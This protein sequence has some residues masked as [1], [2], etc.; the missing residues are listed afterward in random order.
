MSEATE[1]ELEELREELRNERENRQSLEATIEEMDEMIESIAE[2]AERTSVELLKTRSETD[3]IL[4]YVN[5]GLFL[6]DKELC[7]ESQYS[8]AFRDILRLPDEP[9]GSNILKL[10]ESIVRED[11]VAG[12]KIYLKLLMDRDKDPSMLEELNPLRDVE[13]QITS[14]DD[15]VHKFLDFRF[16]RIMQAGDVSGL[17]GVVVDVT[18]HIEMAR[19]VRM[20]EK[21][22]NQDM[23]LM[24]N[25]VNVRPSQLNDFFQGVETELAA[26]E[27]SLQANADPAQFADTLALVFRSMHAIKGYASTLELGL[28]A[29]QAHEAENKIQDLQNKEQLSGA[30]FLPLVMDLHSLRNSYADSKRI[31]QNLK[32]FYA[33][34]SNTEAVDPGA[35]IV[36]QLGD[37]IEKKSRGGLLIAQLLAD[38]F[39]A[40]I[41]PDEKLG[42][43][44]KILIQLVINSL[45][46]GIEDRDARRRRNK[47][48][49]GIIDLRSRVLTDGVEVTYRDDGG[50]LQV[51]KIKKRA[52]EMELRTAGQLEAM[53]SNE[54]SRLI[55]ERGMSTRE[56]ADMTSGRG[57]GM[58]MIMEAVRSIGG[59]IRVVS[60]FGKFTEFRITMS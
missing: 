17:L 34:F 28:F 35:Q 49:I 7:V 15:V 30:D 41:I 1:K 32:S 37:L 46:H 55:F 16:R 24:F 56:E 25:L 14:A 11:L 21:R 5:D 22:A 38:D 59:H 3:T 18:E 47:P 60:S 36:K 44:R 33:E 51:E 2:E 10:L 12:A 54:I 45:V 39:D 6:L 42:A 27:A 9:A 29:E 26:I 58:D 52:L 43:L 40:K 23:K 31:I 8:R 20:A 19:K 48:P 53:D 57:I 13:V 4:H 50:G